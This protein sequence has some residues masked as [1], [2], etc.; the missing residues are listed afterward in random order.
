MSM[1]GAKGLL[2]YMPVSVTVSSPGH[3]VSS[4][5]R[6]HLSVCAL[7]TKGIHLSA[8]DCPPLR[9][10]APF[11]TAPSTVASY[12]FLCTHARLCE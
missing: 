5:S 11:A 9:V 10:T 7:G 12:P 8:G 2:P 3:A 4:G 6:A 1:F